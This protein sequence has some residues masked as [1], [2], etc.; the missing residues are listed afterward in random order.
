MK[1]V[2]LHD[3]CHYDGMYCLRRGEDN[4]HGEGNERECFVYILI[5]LSSYK[6]D[7]DKTGQFVVLRF[8]F[9]MN[10]VE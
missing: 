6:I 9:V 5:I 1:I 7:Y 4:S 2:A 8:M 10:E 3:V